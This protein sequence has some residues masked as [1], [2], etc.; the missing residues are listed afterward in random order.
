MVPLVVPLTDQRLVV[1]Q[2]VARVTA[3][4]HCGPDAKVT[5]VPMPVHGDPRIK[6]GV[7]LQSHTW[8]HRENHHMGAFLGYRKDSQ[9]L[10]H[11]T[12]K[13]FLDVIRPGKLWK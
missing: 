3:E 9:Y 10:C 1:T 7:R 8:T 12:Y 2:R 4:G 11:N 6:A 13:I 5:A